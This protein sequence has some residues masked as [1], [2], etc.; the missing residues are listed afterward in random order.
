MKPVERQ[1]MPQAIA[2]AGI[3]RLNLAFF[4]KIAA[5]VSMRT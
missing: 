4:T 3:M 2:M 5:G 1:T